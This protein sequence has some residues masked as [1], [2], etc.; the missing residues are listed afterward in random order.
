[1]PPG[2]GNCNAAVNDGTTTVGF[3][4]QGGI[5]LCADSRITQGNVILSKSMLKAFPV[6]NH[7]MATVAGGSAECSFWIR[8]LAWEACLHELRNNEPLS[9]LSA[10]TIISNATMDE[11]H[12]GRSLS[13][14][15]ILAG[16]DSSGPALIRVDGDGFIYQGTAFA[17]GSGSASALGILE[18]GF[19][20]HL[21][22]KQ[23]FDLAFR[24]VYHASLAD[25][26]T[27]GA[28]SL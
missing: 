17:V 15:M 4:Y 5:V 11:K 20:Y 14:G 2:H 7:I 8:T 13:M 27:G 26:T 23:A 1:S 3:I 12:N 16:R 24:A 10:A 28:V 18:T 19:D 22:D 21:T 25:G 6:S 9:L